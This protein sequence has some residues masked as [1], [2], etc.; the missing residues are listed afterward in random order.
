MLKRLALG[1]R[2]EALHYH[3]PRSRSQGRLSLLVDGVSARVAIS[4]C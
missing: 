2:K 4:S 1:K 3:S